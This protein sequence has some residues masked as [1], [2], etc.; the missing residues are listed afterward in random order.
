MT[1]VVSFVWVTAIFN[2]FRVAIGNG[3]LAAS[4]AVVSTA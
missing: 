2:R 4:A 3:I 1:S